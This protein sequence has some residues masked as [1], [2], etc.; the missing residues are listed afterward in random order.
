VFEVEEPVLQLEL[1]IEES[2][3]EKFCNVGMFIS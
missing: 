1:M 2:V 3:L